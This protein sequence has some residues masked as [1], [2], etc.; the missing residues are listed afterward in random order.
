MRIKLEPGRIVPQYK[1]PDLNEESV[2]A[3][4]ERAAVTPEQQGGSL[5][6]FVGLNKMVKIVETV[7]SAHEP[8]LEL[9]FVFLQD[10]AISLQV[11]LVE[12][13]REAGQK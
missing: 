6:V 9:V 2:G 8:S 12:L 7:P 3:A 1:R 4:A 10:L 11:F 13:K 5:P